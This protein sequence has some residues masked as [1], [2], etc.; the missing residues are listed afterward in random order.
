MK[1]QALKFQL[2]RCYHFSTEANEYKV[3][4][5]CPL[6][7]G[8]K[9]GIRENAT[10]TK[11]LPKVP[12]VK[13]TYPLK[14]GLPKRKVL[15]QPPFFRCYVSFAECTLQRKLF[16]N[17]PWRIILE[18]LI[19]EWWECPGRTRLGFRSE[20]QQNLR[21]IKWSK[22]RWVFPKIGVPPKNII[23][24]G[25]STWFS[26]SILGDSIIFGSTP[27]YLIC[28]RDPHLHLHFL[29]AFGKRFIPSCIS[30]LVKIKSPWEF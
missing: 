16:H 13:L 8:K 23:L 29:L 28:W 17:Q 20:L 24:I 18:Q 25:F 4:I 1:L 2:Q 27:R 5:D 11:I 3:S 9:D 15:S 14:I 12:S 30:F 26:P 22:W 7:L 19:S 21:V 10:I 6:P